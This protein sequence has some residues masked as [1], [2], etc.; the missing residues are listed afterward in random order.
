M[1]NRGKIRKAGSEDEVGKVSVSVGRGVL[2]P[3]S[4]PRA[5]PCSLGLPHCAL[6]LA[7]STPSHGA[8]QRDGSVPRLHSHPQLPNT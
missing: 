6:G 4:R 7:V 5:C 8:L 1:V 2:R 3:G